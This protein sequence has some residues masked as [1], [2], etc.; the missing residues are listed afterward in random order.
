MTVHKELVADYKLQHPEAKARVVNDLAGVEARWIEGQDI[1]AVYRR[2]ID[3]VSDEELR[4]MLGAHYDS[5][6]DKIRAQIKLMTA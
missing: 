1:K 2:S 4:T 3:Y 6:A 5:L